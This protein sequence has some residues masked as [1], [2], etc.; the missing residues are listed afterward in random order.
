VLFSGVLAR[1]GLQAGQAFGLWA[2]AN[3]MALALA[4][5]LVLPILDASGFRSDQG[6]SPEA[7]ETLTILYAVVP[8][9]LKALAIGLVLL[10]PRK[11]LLQ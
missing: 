10:L 4:A 6:N 5:A 3:K 2:I 9:G 11:A 7:I 8:L 1:A